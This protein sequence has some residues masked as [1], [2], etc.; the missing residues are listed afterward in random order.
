MIED[1][2]V[3]LDLRRDRYFRLLPEIDAVFGR[4]VQAPLALRPEHPPPRSMIANG[5]LVTALPDAMPIAPVAM[6]VPRHSL[7]ER[8]QTPEPRELV[9]FARCARSLL[10][11]ALA[12]RRG[13]LWWLIQ[14]LRRQ[15]ESLGLYQRDNDRTEAVA[16]QFQIWRGFVPV[17]P[18]CLVDS[19]AL[20]DVLL[21]LEHR[22]DLVFGVRLDPFAAHCWVQTETVILNDAVDHARNFRPI[23]VL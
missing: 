18:V 10:G 5:L 6:E 22:A 13:G 2:A 14:R 15:K 11:S 21:R 23:L 17:R 3:F 19:L 16:R 4:H 12:L 9:A 20:L 7:L 1:R 8:E